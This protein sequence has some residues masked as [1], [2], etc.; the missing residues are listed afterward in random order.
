MIRSL[1]EGHSYQEIAR[2]R[3]TSQRTIAN[4]IAAVFHRMAV[5]NRNELVHRLFARSAVRGTR[6]ASAQPTTDWSPLEMA[7]S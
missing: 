1:L 6:S 7:A 3:G 2:R 4:Q 5:S